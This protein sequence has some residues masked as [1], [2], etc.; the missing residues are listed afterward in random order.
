MLE[1]RRT[2]RK[3]GGQPG[4]RMPAIA[5]GSLARAGRGRQDMS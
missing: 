3:K 4:R 1:N 2:F 5:D